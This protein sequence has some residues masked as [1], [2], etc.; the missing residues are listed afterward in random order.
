VHAIYQLEAAHE[1]A[2]AVQGWPKPALGMVLEVNEALLLHLTPLPAFH[3]EGCVCSSLV[4]LNSL[5]YHIL[6]SM[7]PSAQH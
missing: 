7:L 6:V 5:A 1:I 2:M 4:Q 3:H